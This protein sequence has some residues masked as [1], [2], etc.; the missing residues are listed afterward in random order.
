MGKVLANTFLQDFIPMKRIRN[1]HIE[2]KGIN[3]RHMY[4]FC[5]TPTRSQKIV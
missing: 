2:K 5:I 4:C 3:E 1:Y